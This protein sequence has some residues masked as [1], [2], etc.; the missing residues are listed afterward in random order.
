MILSIECKDTTQ[1]PV[2][3]ANSLRPHG[4]DSDV[5]PAVCT[6]AEIESLTKRTRQ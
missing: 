3:P 5:T 6:V 2:E 1:L 4:T